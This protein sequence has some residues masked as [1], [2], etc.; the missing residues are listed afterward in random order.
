M[1]EH[2]RPRAIVGG[3]AA[4]RP[5]GEKVRPVS[6]SIQISRMVI[7]TAALAVLVTM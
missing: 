5:P 4:G 3:I 1:D 2:G 7:A 6:I